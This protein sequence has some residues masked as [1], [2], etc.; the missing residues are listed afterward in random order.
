MS[1]SPNVAYL[2]H[3]EVGVMAVEWVSFSYFPPLKPKCVLWSSVSYSLKTM[4]N[5]TIKAKYSEV[6]TKQMI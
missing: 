4:V 2:A 3:G 5:A 6:G 1:Y